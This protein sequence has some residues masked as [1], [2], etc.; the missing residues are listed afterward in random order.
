MKV[1]RASTTELM[2]LQRDALALM[3]P[4]HMELVYWWYVHIYDITIREISIIK[5]DEVIR[6]S[7]TRPAVSITFH[8]YADEQSALQALIQFK[9]QLVCVK[10]KKDNELLCGNASLKKA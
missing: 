1:G 3:L 5:W 8:V 6:A 10:T 2:S 9:P 7:C 4:W